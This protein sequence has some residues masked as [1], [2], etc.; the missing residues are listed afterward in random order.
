MKS[1]IKP[2]LV[3]FRPNPLLKKCKY[4]VTV[5]LRE[6]DKA[7]WNKTWSYTIQSEKD[8]IDHL[9]GYTPK[10]EDEFFASIQFLDKN[11]KPLNVD[12]GELQK[13]VYEPINTIDDIPS[14]EDK[15]KWTYECNDCEAILSRENDNKI[16]CSGCG[17]SNLKLISYPQGQRP[18][19]IDEEKKEGKKDVNV[20]KNIATPTLPTTRYYI[21]SWGYFNKELK[22]HIEQIEQN[23]FFY[24]F[25]GDKGLVNVEVIKEYDAELNKMV[26]IGMG[27]KI[28]DKLFLF[29]RS[30]YNARLFYNIPSY[31]TINAYLEGKYIPRPYNEIIKDV[32]HIIK[33]LFEFSSLDIETS[34]VF[35][36]QTTLKPILDNFFYYAIDS[37]LGSGKTTLGEIVYFISPHG[38]LGGNISSASIPRLVEELNLNIFVDEID[39]NFKDDDVLAVLRK[40]QRRGNPYVR[41]EGRDNRPVAYDLAG[42]HGC[43][44][45]GELE[46]AFIN[47][48]LRVHTSKSLDYKLPV[49]NSAKKDILKPIADELFIWSLDNLIKLVV[50]CSKE[51]RVATKTSTMTRES[52]FENLTNEL[53]E[54]EKEFLKEV[55]GRDNELTFMVLKTSKLLGVDTLEHLKEIMKQK[56]LNEVSSE[57]FYNDSLRE[58]I[59]QLINKKQ[60]SLFES[61]LTDG[62]NSGCPYYPKSKLYQDFIQYLKYLNV[63][64]IG[65]KKFTSI[66]RDF[67]FI[68]GDTIAS[69]RYGTY[70]TPCL[71][72][73]EHVCK[74]ISCD[75]LLPPKISHEKVTQ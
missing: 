42:C 57:N 31:E 60:D 44:F 65:T 64:T 48:A 58:L 2:K 14:K 55:F 22:I 40:G 17:S 67:G 61:V 3:K 45:R 29:K 41:C 71:I 54:D 66:L 26:K 43:S 13:Y 1:K 28:K 52:I 18:N 34:A 33:Q 35:I 24:N 46:D 53:K 49:I 39:Q 12:I 50:T 68:E 21:N 19:W 16:K 59:H 8:F 20:N 75:S 51:G 25:N 56:K 9:K 37:T 5:A 74:K 38:F 47:R 72:F 4:M 10:G 63:Q 73:N 23:I 11:E 27:F 7:T 70:P 62:I 6:E 15:D 36:G 69:Q 30:I 32:K